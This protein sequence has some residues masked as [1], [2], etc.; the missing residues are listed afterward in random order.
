MRAGAR[1]LFVA[2]VVLVAL[3]GCGSGSSSTSTGHEPET[4]PQRSKGAPVLTDPRP[5]P[6][7]GSAA[8]AAGVPTVKGGDNSIQTYGVE[9][10]SRER[11]RVAVIARSYLKAQA[12]GR[13]GAACDRLIA[14]LHRRLKMLAGGAKSLRG[15]GCA[16]AMAAVVGRASPA[17]LRQSAQIHVLSL[18]V[19][20]KQAFVI[21]RDGSGHPFNLPLVR[22]NGEWKL[23]A[24][25][26]IGLAGMGP[27]VK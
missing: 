15:Q 22:E 8:V 7:Q 1:C 12:S 6:N 25:A 5:L 19:R 20:G 10:D 17:E 2:A 14:L 11:A 3:A 9:A 27:S 21:Y 23:S 4:T 16:G 26:G 24:L 18:R 13:W